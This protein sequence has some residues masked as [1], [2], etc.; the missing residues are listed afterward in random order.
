MYPT[1]VFQLIVSC[2]AHLCVR[3]MTELLPKSPSNGGV[4]LFGKTT[5]NGFIDFQLVS[6]ELYRS[7]CDGTRITRPAGTD[8]L[9]IFFIL[10]ICL[11][12]VI[13][14]LLYLAVERSYMLYCTSVRRK[15]R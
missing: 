1:F 4:E 12:S 15:E 2:V 10:L 6:T 7:V 5:Q 9:R 3:N 11:I 13:R 14:V 8:F